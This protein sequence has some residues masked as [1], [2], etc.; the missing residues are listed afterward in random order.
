MNA[1]PIMKCSSCETLTRE[2]DAEGRCAICASGVPYRP[3]GP[4]ERAPRPVCK[5]PECDHTEWQGGYCQK[6]YRQ[7]QK[8]EQL[9]R[10]GRGGGNEH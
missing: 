6:H 8:A 4:K 10:A 9:E 1:L 5:E 2:P 7:S 3:T